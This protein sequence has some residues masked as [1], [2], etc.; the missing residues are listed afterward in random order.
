MKARA[1]SGGKKAEGFGAPSPVCGFGGYANLYISVP[2]W[3]RLLIFEGMAKKYYRSS[4]FYW[5][6]PPRS[7]P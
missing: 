3:R 7:I 6:L 2:F 4:A 5:K 1:R